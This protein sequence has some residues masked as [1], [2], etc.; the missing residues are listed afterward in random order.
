MF[1][2]SIL[3]VHVLIVIED[4][5]VAVQ[6]NLVL[7][8]LILSSLA[9]AQSSSPAPSPVARRTPPVFSLV[10]HWA[11]LPTILV[12]ALKTPSTGEKAISPVNFTGRPHQRIFLERK[13]RKCLQTPPAFA[14]LF[15]YGS[16][17]LLAVAA[18]RPVASSAT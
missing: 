4:Y 12:T 3:R 2:C 10:P 5:S 16:G 11:A 6:Y 17:W 7:S 13:P 1:L 9:P 15:N 8:G 18:C 14:L